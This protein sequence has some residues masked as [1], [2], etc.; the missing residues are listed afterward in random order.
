MVGRYFDPRT[1]RRS[2]GDYRLQIY[3]IWGADQKRMGSVELLQNDAS[4][5]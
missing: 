2:H 4:Y 5:M 3:S 1:E